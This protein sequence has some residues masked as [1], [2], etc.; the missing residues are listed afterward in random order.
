MLR[1]RI[2]RVGASSR[3][4]HQGSIG[5]SLSIR[6]QGLTTAFAAVLLLAGCSDLDDGPVA[7][8]VPARPNASPTAQEHMRPIEQHF[9]QLG[10]DVSGFGGYYYD[11]D[12][13]LVAYVTDRAQEA[14]AKAILEPV[15]RGRRA[16][17][18]ERRSRRPEVMIRLGQYGFSQLAGWRDRVS[19]ELMNTD[20]VVHL[21]ADEVRNRITVGLDRARFAAMRQTVEAML[22]RAGVPLESVVFEE[23][24]PSWYGAADPGYLEPASLQTYQG[25]LQGGV[26]IA[27]G[28]GY[29]TLGF[30]AVLNGVAVFMTNS[31]CT[32]TYWGRDYT[33]FTQPDIYDPIVGQEYADYSGKSCGFLSPNKC[34]YADVA[35][36]RV[37]GGVSTHFGRIARTTYYAYGRGNSGSL[38]IDQNNPHFII[39][40]KAQYP[41]TGEYMDKVGRTTGWTYG[42]VSRT[43]VERR[44][45]NGKVL[46]CQDYAK[47]GSQR[48]DSGSPVFKWNFDNTV[49]LYGIHWGS[50]TDTNEAMFSSVYNIERDLGTISVVASTGGWTPPPGYEEPPPPTGLHGGPDVSVLKQG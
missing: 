44:L 31:H 32:S 36:I 35:A 28:S 29:C 37:L 13:N 46:R 48:G 20:G 9:A 17:G 18:R 21:D 41:V 38:T 2:G 30:N 15:L 6:R 40:A 10:R 19:D 45:G 49:T 25:P 50:A 1:D 12:G 7:P 26:Q 33:V 39:T 22:T 4:T 42:E 8:A 16:G 43:C 5:F 34:R 27:N 24:D 14:R 11:R 23:A 47:Y 3:R